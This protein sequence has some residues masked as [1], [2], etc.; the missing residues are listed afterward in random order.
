M[1]QRTCNI[2]MICKGNY[3]YYANDT[4]DAIKRYM[5]HECAVD[6]SIYDYG[7]LFNSI[8]IEAMLDYMNSMTQRPSVFMREFFHWFN[9]QP[10]TQNIIDSFALTQVRDN[11]GCINGFTEEM[12]EQSARELDF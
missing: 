5:A 6:K 7:N 2:I 10:L 12:M 8:L 11:G 4:V 9:E 3:K 1:T